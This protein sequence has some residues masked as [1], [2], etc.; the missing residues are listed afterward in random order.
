MPSTEP[1]V[2]ELILRYWAHAQSY[3][4]HPDGATTGEHLVIRCELK[5]LQLCVI[6]MFHER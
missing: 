6:D 4:R 2:A 5:P 3:Y 1:T